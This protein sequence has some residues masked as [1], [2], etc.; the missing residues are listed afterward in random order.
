MTNHSQAT[1]RWLLY[2]SFILAAVAAFF[3]YQAVVEFTFITALTK[4]GALVNGTVV[5]IAEQRG[6]YNTTI[7]TVEYQANHQPYHVT[8]RFTSNDARY[9]LQ[10][11]VT[12]LYNT[13]SP[14]TAIINDAHERNLWAFNALLSVLIFVFGGAFFK[15]YKASSV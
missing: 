11:A 2:A 6:R 13:A 9:K 15:A 12:V 4:Q 7:Y 14:E 8:N 5:D 3:C 1:N 10:E